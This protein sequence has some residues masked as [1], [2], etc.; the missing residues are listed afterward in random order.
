MSMSLVDSS[1]LYIVVGLF[2]DHL[3]VFFGIIGGV[4]QGI[5]LYGGLIIALGGFSDMPALLFL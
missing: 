2:F 1:A 4:L 5:G 3:G